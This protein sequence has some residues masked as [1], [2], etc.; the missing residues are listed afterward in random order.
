MRLLP[1][2]LALMLVGCAA[3]HIPVCYR[4]E[5]GK[6]LCLT[7]GT[8]PFCPKNGYG[9]V[10]GCDIPSPS[11]GTDDQQAKMLDKLCTDFQSRLRDLEECPKGQTCLESHYC[12]CLKREFTDSP[13]ITY[14]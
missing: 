3:R 1:L 14:Y 8:K 12:E 5:T 11:Q 4:L 13:C 9:L 10:E 2:L 7:P 6:L